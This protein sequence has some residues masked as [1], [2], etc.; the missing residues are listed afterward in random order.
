MLSNPN[1]SQIIPKAGNRYESALA[2]AKRA[3]NIE[4]KRIIEGD[5]DITDSVDIAAKEIAEGK[6]RVKKDGEYVVKEENENI[7]TNDI[8]DVVVE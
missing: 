3:R 8:N 1:V 7:I 2:I 6:V 5:R 4:S